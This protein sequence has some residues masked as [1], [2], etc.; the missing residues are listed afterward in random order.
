MSIQYF[1]FLRVVACVTVGV[2]LSISANSGQDP[3][4]RKD[5]VGP[6]FGLR[7]IPGSKISG[8]RRMKFFADGTY[9]SENPEGRGTFT[10]EGDEVTS[11]NQWTFKY[12]KGT[13][14]D[15]AGTLI[16]GTSEK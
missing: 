11:P 4:Q 12:H 6:W 16:R 15:G 7:T 2:F 1:T 3:L 9:V 13:L 8:V 10:I 14:K 5:L